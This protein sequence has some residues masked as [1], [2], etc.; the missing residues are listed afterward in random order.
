[1]TV[2]TEW[3]INCKRCGKPFGYSDR[4]YVNSLQYGFS[5]P[6]YCEEC[7]K[8]HKSEKKTMGVSYFRLQPT[9]Q[10]SRTNSVYHPPRTHVAKTGEGQF[11]AEKFGLTPEKIKELAM[12]FADPRHRV[13]V[14]VGPTGSGKSVALPYWLINVPDGIGV[15]PDFFTRDGQMLH[16]Q[17]RQI[18]A[19]TQTEYVGETLMGGSVGAGFDVGYVY[20]GH[21]ETDWRNSWVSCTDGIFINEIVKGKLGNYGYVI[22]DEAHERSVNIEEILRLLSER[23]ALYPKLKLIIASATI[24]ADFFCSFF[25]KD[26]AGVVAFEGKDRVDAHGKPVKYDVFYQDEEKA[27]PY[28]DLASLGKVVV[29]AA[30]EKALWI[31]DEIKAK[32]KKRGDILIFLQGAGPINEAVER[33]RSIISDDPDLAN[34]VEAYPLYRDL[35]DHEKKKITSHNLKD[36]KIWLIFST[37]IAEA[38][39]TIDSLGYEVETGV[40]N[41]AVF[42]SEK[43]ILEVLLNM[44]SQANAKQRWGR[45]GRTSDGEVY[46]LYTETQFNTLFPAYPVAA[47]KRSNMEEPFLTLKLAGIPHPETGW[48][49]NPKEDEVIRANSALSTSGAVGENG[50]LTKRGLVLRNISYP[51]KLID[52]LFTADSIGCVVEVASL[53]PVIKNGGSNRILSWKYSWD[54]YTKYDAV[55]KH[56][57]LLGGCRDDIEFILKIIKAWIDLPWID[58]SAFDN[59]S[60]QQIKALRRDW[61]ERNFINADVLETIVSERDDVLEGFFGKTKDADVRSLNLMLVSRV[62]ALLLGIFPEIKQLNPQSPYVFNPF[63]EIEE[64]TS[65]TCHCIP[66]EHA[67][68]KDQSWM[69]VVSQKMG[70]YKK[71]LYARLFVEQVYPIAARF[72]TKQLIQSEKGMML[73]RVESVRQTIFASAQEEVIALDETDQQKEYSFQELLDE[74]HGEE[75][76]SEEVIEYSLDNVPVNYNEVPTH[77]CC[78]EEVPITDKQV[79]YEVIGY[80]YGKLPTVLVRPVPIPEPYQAF[81]KMFRVG[82]EV[83]VEVVYIMSYPNDHRPA[84]VV[85]EQRSKLEILVEAAEISFSNTPAV[86]T[87]IPVGSVLRMQ[88]E[89]VRKD[90]RRIHLS[91]LAMT[92]KT[93]SEL[94]EQEENGG[95]EKNQTTAAQTVEVKDESVH[96]LL[97]WAKPEHGFMPVVSVFEDR[98]PKAIS[99][100]QVGEEVLLSVYRKNRKPVRTGLAELPKKAAFLLEGGQAP[101]GLSYANQTLEFAGRMS[102]DVRFELKTLANDEAYHMAIDKLYWLSNRVF[103]DSFIDNEWFKA[104]KEKY[105]INSGVV[106]VIQSVSKSGIT[107]KVDDMDAFI[108]RSLTGGDRRADI[109]KQFHPGDTIHAQVVEIEAGK[110]QLILQFAT[111]TQKAEFSIGQTVTATIQ[112]F[113]NFGMFV[114]LGP[115]VE[116]LVRSQ[117]IYRGSKK[118]EELFQVDQEVR[119]EILSMNE[120]GIELTMKIAEN[121]PFETLEEGDE[122]EGKV[123]RIMDFGIFVEVAP[124]VDGLLHESQMGDLGLEDFTEGEEIT[125]TI[126]RIDSDERRI[127]LTLDD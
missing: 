72:Q 96:F 3:S 109:L 111:D 7:Q 36:G 115:G 58:G 92:E 54:A 61:A 21:H 62:R 52:A 89:R 103:V 76:Q 87:E 20:S 27:L 45:T 34:F 5:R 14:V 66:V 86:I 1:M 18:S 104:T 10:I 43:A 59:L 55:R 98:L 47:I 8:T 81:T 64:G 49:E 121:D 42:N 31:V 39:V 4:S 71:I 25:G 117:N 77:I 30:I 22:L 44:I 99:S 124:G 102:D 126:R 57:A 63:E 118:M 78:C 84:L 73:Q 26:V 40:E 65:V 17:P 35:P 120:R 19:R 93:L 38:S 82:N 122:V 95:R 16:T 50:I 56:K 94:F 37:N 97:A 68:A 41:Q 48:L 2:T 23:L 51:T 116:G 105:P 88:Y 6:E 33:V 123:R 60:K 28:D 70:G 67:M 53:F 114:R 85:R 112:K 15:P 101:E 119:A 108:P 29:T 106:G 11:K 107:L 125:V 80:E 79:E 90:A 9:A 127:S 91:M 113:T 100:F 24:D 74:E 75:D 69:D 32:R 46:C 83:T 110:K 13:A 12:W